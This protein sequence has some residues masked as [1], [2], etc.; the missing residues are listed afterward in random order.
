MDQL[1][2]FL[3]LRF[4][5]SKAMAWLSRRSGP[6]NLQG[7]SPRHFLPGRDLDEVRDALLRQ[8]ALP[9]VLSGGEARRVGAV[10]GS[11]VVGAGSLASEVQV[12]HGCREPRAHVGR[13]PDHVARVGPERVRIRAPARD[14]IL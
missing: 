2:S 7:D 13:L 12:V 10:D 1:A 14:Q 6:A 9:A 3:Q 11:G 4:D 8:E 5:Q